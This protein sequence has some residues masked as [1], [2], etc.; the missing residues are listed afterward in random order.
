LQRT[1]PICS[2]IERS[3]SISNGPSENSTLCITDTSYSIVKLQKGLL[4]PHLR[5]CCASVNDLWA[6]ETC[7][8]F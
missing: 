4:C 6:N 2:F 3:I 5:I 8:F 1:I 7:R